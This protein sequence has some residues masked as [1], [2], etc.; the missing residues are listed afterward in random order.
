M[1]SASLPEFDAFCE[2]Q[3]ARKPFWS[4]D[5]RFW[6][7]A[8]GFRDGSSVTGNCGADRPFDSAPPTFTMN[9]PRF[10]GAIHNPKRASLI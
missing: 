2:N 1:Q 8:L 5:T 3:F 4:K 9:R 7:E 6:R 10:A